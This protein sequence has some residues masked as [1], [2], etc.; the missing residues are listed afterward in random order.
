MLGVAVPYAMGNALLT[1]L[2]QNDRDTRVRAPGSISQVF[3][4]VTSVKPLIYRNVAPLA[5]AH[6]SQSGVS[7]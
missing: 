7:R 3:H 6:R 5:K 1:M 4:V 2:G